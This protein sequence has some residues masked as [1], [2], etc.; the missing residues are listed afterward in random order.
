MFVQYVIYVQYI[1]FLEN[2]P[3]CSGVLC[4][5]TL[6]AA[7]SKLGLPHPQFTDKQRQLSVVKVLGTAGSAI[8][9]RG[10][11]FAVSKVETSNGTWVWEV[12]SCLKNPPT[13]LRRCRVC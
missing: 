10:P 11:M 12:R 13:P 9:E 7:A 1:M 3:V 8:G 5:G 6:E 2:G 4:G